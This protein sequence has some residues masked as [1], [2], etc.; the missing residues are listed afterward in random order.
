MAGHSKWANIKRRKGKAD[1]IKGKLFSRLTKEIITAVK[2]GGGSDPKTNARLRLAIQKARAGN[3]PGE[4]IERNI[5]KASSQDQ[6]DFVSILYELYGHGGVGILVE[7]LT[8]NKNRISSDIRI[9]TNKRGGT[10]AS[11]GAV[12][13]N[14]DHKGVLQFKREQINEE[15]LLT[16]AT[17]LG[18]E[19][20]EV[21]E[22][23]C[24]VITAPE[25]LYAV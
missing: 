19:D 13:F 20:L 21:D 11:P 22:S 18:A 7:V 6:A 3:L 23:F 1:A 24:L 2:Q 12:A 17:E 9:A 25:Q 5:K 4:T 14:F 16:L 8:D 15:A 10:I